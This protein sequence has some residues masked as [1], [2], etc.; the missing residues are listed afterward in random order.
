MSQGFELK[1][2]GAIARVT[3]DRSEVGNML[4]LAQVSGLARAVREAGSDAAVKAIVLGGK[5]DDFCRGRDPAGAPEAKP[6]TAVEMR[7]A[8]IEP[9]LGLY[10]AIRDAAVPVVA[11]VQ[12]SARGL[13]CGVAAVCDVAIAADSARFSLPEMKANLPPTLAMLAHL[14]RVPSKALLWMVLS[15]GEIDANRARDWGLVSEV[16]PAADLQARAEAFLNG[17]AG[18]ERDPLATCK[19]YLQRARQADYA[20]ANDLAGNLLSVVL[21]SR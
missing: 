11:V 21:S 3:L 1:R 20:T 7:N 5:G 19:S 16:A 14:D 8:L 17:L 2:D 18:F 13:G 12:G 9:I 15:T 4:T 10:R 6:T